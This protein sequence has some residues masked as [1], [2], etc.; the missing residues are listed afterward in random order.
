MIKNN[1][2][3]EWYFNGQEKIACKD[4]GRLFPSYQP[5][6][7]DKHYHN[8][9]SPE[10]IHARQQARIKN[11][12]E[13]IRV[14]GVKV[15]HLEDRAKSIDGEINHAARYKKFL[16]ITGDWRKHKYLLINKK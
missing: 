10:A 12:V 14:L 5:K 9:H 1:G 13:A 4:C 11:A 6:L 15:K 8:A 7:L 2:Y 3:L 16:G